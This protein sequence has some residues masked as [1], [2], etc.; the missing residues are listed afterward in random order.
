MNY[1]LK[2]LSAEIGVDEDVIADA[3]RIMGY[4]RVGPLLCLSTKMSRAFVL[5]A[6]DLQAMKNAAVERTRLRLAMP[7]NVENPTP[8]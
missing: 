4:R 3:A 7:V 6:Q 1:S 2:R 5:E 8:R